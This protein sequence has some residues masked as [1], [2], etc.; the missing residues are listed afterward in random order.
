MGVE[1]AQL[2]HGQRGFRVIAQHYQRVFAISG[3]TQGHVKNHAGRPVQLHVGLFQHRLGQ[4]GAARHAA[5]HLADLHAGGRSAGRKPQIAAHKL[6]GLAGHKGLG[7]RVIPEGADRM[8]LA[9]GGHG[10]QPLPHKHAGGAGSSPAENFHRFGSR[11]NMGRDGEQARQHAGGV[12]R[13]FHIQRDAVK[14]D[15]FQ[16]FSRA[17]AFAPEADLNLTQV[18]QFR[19]GRTEILHRAA[20]ALTA[21]P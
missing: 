19:G 14:G 3:Q 17:E 9:Q 8:H 7:Q 11:R 20:H 10:Q 1:T 5:L 6:R 12:G 16:L 21:H 13:G 2:G 18:F 15:A 4:N